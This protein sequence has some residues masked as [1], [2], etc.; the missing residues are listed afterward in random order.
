MQLLNAALSYN[1]AG[2]KVVP[3][4]KRA[5]GSFTFPSWA[6]YRET[7]S[8]D[9]VRKLFAS[10]PS[11]AT[12]WG[13]AILMTDDLETVDIDTKAD[14]TGEVW[15]KFQE[16]ILWATGANDP[17]Y[18]AT[19]IK[20]KS[21]GY[22]L[23]YRTRKPAP[24]RKLTMTQSGA[25]T[26]ETR[27]TNALIFAAPT[28]GYEIQHGTYEAIPYLSDADRDGLINAALNLSYRA[29]APLPTDVTR[30]FTSTDATDQTPWDAFNARHNCD[31]ILQA[32]GWQ[33]TRSHGNFDYYSKPNAS[34][35][36]D[37]HGAVI[38]DKN[39]FHPF[40]TATAF[41]AEKNYN[42]YALFTV[43]EF[44]GDFK[45]SARACLEKGYGNVRNSRIPAVVDVRIGSPTPIIPTAE[46]RPPDDD[47]FLQFLRGTMF[48]INNP[49]K[50]E[51]VVL[52][53]FTEGKVHKIA[54]TGGIVA[55][56]GEQ[57][58]GKSM[59]VSAITASALAQKRVLGF[60]QQD[61]GGRKI[62]FDTEQP[63]FFYGM[64][65]KRIYRMA[66]MSAN[67]RDYETYHLRRLDTKQRVKAIDLILSQPGRIDFVVIDGIVDLC[68][69]FNDTKES[70]AVI[71]R[72]L[73]WSD[74]TK[75][76]F[77]VV[78]H[79]T[80]TN[81]FMRGHLGTELQNKIDSSIETSFDKSSNVFKVK[82]RD[83]R[84]WAP[85]PAFEFERDNETGDP[86]VPSMI[87][88]PV[89]KIP[90]N[91]PALLRMERPNADD[92]V[93]F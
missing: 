83:A 42:P 6:Q 14:P 35:A 62:Y 46:T 78:L 20:T 15:T 92:Y 68:D 18:R 66:G 22:H 3:A 77:Y 54:P 70:K 1:A 80:K 43:L 36:R 59:I 25:C 76:L 39:I 8:A 51:E 72:L 17:I 44:S 90:I 34:N 30:E 69:D 50:E 27:G 48:D 13:V 28:P 85:F 9:D 60:Q 21:G 32:Y 64:S 19:C 56:V 67:R 63:L 53:V 5:D 33:K 38:K 84:G 37:T 93:P 49:P 89:E 11:G 12:L 31:E 81:G 73:Q 74:K 82:N 4:F 79:T 91:S 24:S 87:L 55:V 52:T 86:F 40:T 16:E 10:V 23:V 71:S 58:S 29:P 61:T 45:A 88:D 2:L 26:I 75:A 57:K 65:Q 41:E 47:S 7:Q